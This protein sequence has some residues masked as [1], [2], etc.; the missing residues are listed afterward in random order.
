MTRTASHSSMIFTP[1]R[2]GCLP[3][4]AGRDMRSISLE[5]LTLG[6]R[7][8]AKPIASNHFQVPGAMCTVIHSV[9]VTPT[10]KSLNTRK[11]HSWHNLY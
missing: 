2:R 7:M 9:A 11:P 1:P 4:L 3:P 6:E 5:E 8:P 10:P